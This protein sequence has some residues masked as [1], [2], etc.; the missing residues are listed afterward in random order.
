MYMMS[1]HT[2]IVSTS[3]SL[4]DVDVKPSLSKG[5]RHVPSIDSDKATSGFPRP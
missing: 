1:R 2:E 5:F 4:G 3:G